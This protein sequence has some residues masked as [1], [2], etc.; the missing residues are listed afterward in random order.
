M[1]G[2]RGA[3]VFTLKLERQVAAAQSPEPRRRLNTDFSNAITNDDRLLESIAGYAPEYAESRRGAT[4]A[5]DE[6]RA[7]L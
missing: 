6:L 2:T 7:I 4:I 3:G 1:V 5:F